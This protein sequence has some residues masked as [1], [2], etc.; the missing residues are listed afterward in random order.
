METEIPTK[1]DCPRC[2]YPL[3]RLGDVLCCQVCQ[4]DYP[5]PEDQRLRSMGAKGLLPEERFDD[6]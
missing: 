3:V 5:L 1:L 2:R 4:E 6:P